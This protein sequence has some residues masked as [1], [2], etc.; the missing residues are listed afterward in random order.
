MEDGFRKND[1]IAAYLR[2]FEAQEEEVEK[3]E[4]IEIVNTERLL[5]MVFVTSVVPMH[6]STEMMEAVFATHM[7]QEPLLEMCE[8]IIVCDKPKITDKKAMY[9][10]GRVSEEEAANYAKYVDSLEKFC[11]EGKWPFVK[12]K[13]VRMEMFGGFGMSLKRGLE[14]L[15]TPYAMI[16]Q[17]DRCLKASFDVEDL[18]LTF[19][20]S[21]QINYIG[22][23]S[24]STCGSHKKYIGFGIKCHKIETEKKRTLAA[25][26]FWFD[27]THIA[28]VPFYLDFIYGWHCMPGRFSL[29]EKKKNN[30]FSFS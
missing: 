19:E 18:L 16:I 26:P 21:P 3:K 11:A 10:K 25:I 9:K 28:R 1:Y 12:T 15:K 13:V 5:S 20:N 27:S 29:R 17:H 30:S 4:R 2:K 7:K 24:N 23:A 14:L 8:K 22:L 6:P